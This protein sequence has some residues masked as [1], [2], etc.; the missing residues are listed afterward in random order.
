M[1]YINKRVKLIQIDNKLHIYFNTKLIRIH[2]ISENKIN[3]NQFDYTEALRT[4]IKNKDYDVEQIAIE[5]L[6]LLNLKGDS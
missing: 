1:Q 4:R 3:Y 2:E 6:K 5:N